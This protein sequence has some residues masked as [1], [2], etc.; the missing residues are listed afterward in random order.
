MRLAATVDGKRVTVTI[1]PGSFS[2]TD[3][4]LEGTDAVLITHGHADHLDADAVMC[5]VLAHPGVPV[6]APADVIDT[7]SS[8]QDA[9]EA[10]HLL[11]ALEP[12][13]EVEVAG[14]HVRT[15]GGQHALIHPLLRTIDNLGYV[16]EGRVYHP[17]D[18]L[19]VPAGEADL[20]LLLVPAWAPWSKTSEVV[21]F[22][23]AVR[24]RRARGIHDAPLNEQG[25]GIVEAQ[26]KN[27]GGRTGTEYLPWASGEE[28]TA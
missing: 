4:A 23:A 27:L 1:D 26:L 7:L 8:R 24:A 9:A 15:V 14:L 28:V 16:I 5:H 21:D 2:D 13:T 18:S 25:H 11:V 6:Y 19:I 20:E 17:G 12:D 3:A 22:M 10:E